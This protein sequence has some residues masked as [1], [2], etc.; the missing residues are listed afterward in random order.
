MCHQ[1]AKGM[2]TH[3]LRTN[4]S[5]PFSVP[6]P[7]VSPTNNSIKK[8]KD[9]PISVAALLLLSSSRG[10]RLF[11]FKT[12]LLK[13]NS[14]LKKKIEL[15]KSWKEWEKNQETKQEIVLLALSN[16]V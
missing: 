8:K 7:P 15:I 14:S 5:H 3:R 4:C 13:T 1:T 6:T 9:F 2:G 10:S 11:H 12:P 16:L